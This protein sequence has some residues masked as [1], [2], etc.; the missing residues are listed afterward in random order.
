MFCLDMT[1]KM[2]FMSCFIVTICTWKCLSFMNRLDVC[3][4][5]TLHS[6]FGVATGAWKWF[7]HSPQFASSMSCNLSLSVDFNFKLNNIKYWVDTKNKLLSHL[8]TARWWWGWTRRCPGWRRLPAPRWAPTR[9]WCSPPITAAL[10]SS[11]AS[12]P[13][14]APANTP[15][16]RWIDNIYRYIYKLV[17]NP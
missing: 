7:L 11:A 13:R 3:L 4:K 16:S 12:T 1:L 8:S 6:K 2:S 5:A 10:S 17:A 14:S 15:A 9:C